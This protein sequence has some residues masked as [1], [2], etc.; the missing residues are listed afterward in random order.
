MSALTELMATVRALKQRVGQLERM[1]I[2][3]PVIVRAQT[4]SAQ[5]I[6]NDT[7]EIVNFDTINY[8]THDA[9]T[10]G[11]NWVFTAPVAGYF[12]VS[13]A[14]LFET[15]TAWAE[16]ERAGLYLYRDG[17]R[18]AGLD[19]GSHWDTSASTNLRFVGGGTV[20]YCAVDQ[21]LNI[22]VYQDSGGAIALNNS[23]SGALWNHVSIT[24]VS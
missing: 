6:P 10:V 13:A 17:S 2:P 5:S 3:A 15:S 19:R 11:S 9:V 8:D 1:E 12:L 24:K 16:S 21:E 4:D 22:R 20:V 7:N 14:L 23:S 18:F